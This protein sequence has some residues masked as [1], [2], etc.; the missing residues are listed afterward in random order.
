MEP[1]VL[2][3]DNHCLAVAKPAPLLTQ[4]VPARAAVA[5]SAGPRITCGRS[6]AS[7]ATSTS[8]FR[9]DST[10]RSPASCCSPA[11]RRPPPGW[12]SN[13]RSTRSKRSTG[14]SSTGRS[15]RPKASGKIVFARCRT[16]PGSKSCRPDTPGAK[17]A[18]L[19]YRML[20]TGRGRDAPGIAADDRADAPAARADG[21]PRLS[22]PR[23]RALRLDDAVRPAGRIAARPGHRPARPPPDVPAP[24]PLRAGHGHRPIAGLIGRQ[25]L[26][27]AR[28]ASLVERQRSSANRP[29]ASRRTDA[30]PRPAANG[31][32]P[33]RPGRPRL[34]LGPLDPARRRPPTTRLHAAE[35]AVCLRRPRTVHRREDD[36]D[37][38]RQAPRGLR[39][40]P[41]QGAVEVSGPAHASR[42][43]N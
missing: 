28:R 15:S 33:P 21:G 18:A 27:F 14:R 26:P 42:S 19:Q 22:D 37:P 7:P 20:A 25:S 36:G 17:S 24:D 5:R 13:S 1:V 6:T 39:R 32:G 41:Q 12:R 38:P 3:E 40:Q 8:A 30:F 35:A 10:G 9:T 43:T 31:S 34:T 16:R 23:R 2:F 4:G 11:T 29:P